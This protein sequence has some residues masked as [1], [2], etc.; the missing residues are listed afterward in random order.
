MKAKD[1]VEQAKKIN[2]VINNKLSEI[3]FWSAVST[4]TTAG[5][6]GE[7]VQ[8]S[9]SNQKMADAVIS[10]SDLEREV[11]KDIQEQFAKRKEI[12]D[13]LEQLTDER[14]YTILYEMYIGKLKCNPDKTFTTVYKDLDEIAALYDRSRSWADSAHGIALKNL[15]NILDCKCENL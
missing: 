3:D 10:K 9:G 6:Y 5:M 1:Y 8:T 7:R 14:D 2:S 12:T 11:E 4:R 13:K 15:Q